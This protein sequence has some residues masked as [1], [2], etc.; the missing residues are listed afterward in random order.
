VGSA[1]SSW[2]HLLQRFEFVHRHVMNGRKHVRRQK[3]IIARL[4][5]EGLS[6]KEAES[7]LQ[8]FE[9]TLKIFEELYEMIKKELGTRPKK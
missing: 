7:L 8:Q 9:T 1:V 3:E 2:D 4:E 6:T 5:S